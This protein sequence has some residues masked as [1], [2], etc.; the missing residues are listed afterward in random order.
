MTDMVPSDV[1]SDGGDDDLLFM[2]DEGPAEPAGATLAPWIVLVVDDDDAVHA[3]SRL[4]LGEI[5]YKDR[6][7]EVLSCFSGREACALFDRRSDIAV[8][9]LDVVMESDDAGLKVARHVREVAG[10][11]KVRIVLRTGQP[12]QAPERDVILNYDINDY[13]SKTELSAQKLYTTMITA[14][15]SYEGLLE[16]EASREGLRRIADASGELFALRQPEAF[17]AR[18][19]GELTDFVGSSEG[20]IFTRPT[21]SETGPDQDRAWRSI[22]IRGWPIEHGTDVLVNVAATAEAG[23][24]RF[25]PSCSY[26]HVAT[27]DGRE[28]VI[29]LAHET[30]MAATTRDLL[31]L[32]AAKIGIGYDNVLMHRARELANLKL[33]DELSQASSHLET[34]RRRLADELKLAHAV[35][36]SILPQAF[37]PGAAI[38]AR[39]LPVA[40]IGGNFYDV[41]ALPGNRLGFVMAGVSGVGVPAALFMMRV[42]QLVRET[43]AGGAGP[44]DGLARINQALCADNPLELSATMVLV[45]LEP[46]TGALIYAA[47]GNELPVWQAADGVIRPLPAANG[48]MLGQLGDARF[49]QASVMMGLGDRLVLHASGVCGVT[50]PDGTAFGLERLQNAIVE[51]RQ[52][53]PARALDHVIEHLRYHA[54]G[55][56]QLSD[57][58]CLFLDRVAVSG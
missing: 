55:A 2:A 46:A 35:Q 32:F 20:A 51:G 4:V 37:P 14:L 16:I 15:R 13:K 44:A 21:A 18:T 49:E 12:G 24:S 57:I 7:L 42:H 8:V 58:A 25:E 47:A 23:A 56:A 39:L 11:H 10:N 33:T 28:L 22:A 29:Y 48:P 50:A 9:L 26:V 6:A 30:A 27:G 54:A 3:V 45:M 40:G 31:G 1:P 5:T 34:A 41:I 17:I 53:E 19:I 52:V 36:R 43:V 38:A